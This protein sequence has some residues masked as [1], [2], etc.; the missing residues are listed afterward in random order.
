MRSAIMTRNDIH[1]HRINRVIALG[2]WKLRQIRIMHHLA[3]SVCGIILILIN[4]VIF[5]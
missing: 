1:Q 2:R 4:L 3:I 5:L